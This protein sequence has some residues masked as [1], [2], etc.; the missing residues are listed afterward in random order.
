[1]AAVVIEESKEISSNMKGFIFFFSGQ[2]VSILGSSIIQFVI[3]WWITVETQS[4]LLLSLS[5]FIGFIP[6]IILTPIAG[7]FVDRWNMKA[8]IAIVDFLQA[9]VTVVLIVLF[10]FNIVTIP[11]VFIF[12]A[13]RGIFQAFHQPAV[14][15]LIPIMVP[16]KHLSRMNSVSY[17]FTS[18][19]FLV[20]PIFGAF[21]NSLWDIKYILWIDMITFGI[22][23][24]PLLIIKIPRVQKVEAVV[25]EKRKFFT[26]FK[27][28][29]VF[30]KNK[31]GLLPLLGAF[32]IANLFIMPLFTLLNLYVY[33]NHGGNENNLAFVLAFNQIGTIIGSIVFI[34]W[35]GFKKKIHGVSIGI[36]FM[37]VGFITI[38]FTPIGMFWFMGIGFLIIGLMLPVANISSQT[39]WQALVPKEMLGRVMSVRAAIAQFIS[40]LGMI[41]SG[42]IAEVVDIKYVFLGSAALGLCG[43]IFMFIFTPARHVEQGINYE[44][45]PQ[46]KLKILEIPILDPDQTFEEYPPNIAKPAV[47]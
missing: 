14:Q 45:E 20:G 18:V 11:I 16:R 13:M 47:E 9:A 28:G 32:S 2:L 21:L 24:I 29:I 23:L 4:A 33:T 37:Y 19:I 12:T 41:L 26:D 44:E 6:I 15:A 38:A 35:K 10:I 5:M 1:M 43:L 36:F 40:P 8:L 42:L 46:M 3:T 31:K 17:L 39:I 34:I 27:E 7:V 25:K 30:I 22:A